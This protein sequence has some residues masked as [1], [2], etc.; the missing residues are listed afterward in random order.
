M[1]LVRG[2]LELETGDLRDLGSDLDI[3]A[4][5]GV[6]TLGACQLVLSA[7]NALLTV[8]TAVPPCAK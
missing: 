7:V 8:P 1:Y 2:S 3:E 6:E 5:L 4:L